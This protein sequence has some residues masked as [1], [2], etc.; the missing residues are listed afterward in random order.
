MIYKSIFVFVVLSFILL[1]VFKFMSLPPITAL[2]NLNLNNYHPSVLAYQQPHPF[3]GSPH[4][5]LHM[6]QPSNMTP[7]ALPNECRYIEKWGEKYEIHKTS[8]T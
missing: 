3:L 2:D 4:H 6:Y 7:Y 1:S 8:S 5:S